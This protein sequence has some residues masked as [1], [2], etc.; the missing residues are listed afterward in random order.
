MLL[1]TCSG[2]NRSAHL[3]IA[4]GKPVS[5][6][7][8]REE[9]LV[10][11]V[12]TLVGVCLSTDRGNSQQRCLHSANMPDLEEK[13][14]KKLTESV[15]CRGR[16][17]LITKGRWELTRI[18]CMQRASLSHY[19]QGVE[20]ALAV[21]GSRSRRRSLGAY[22]TLIED[23]SHQRKYN[24]PPPPPALLRHGTI[25]RDLETCS[26]DKYLKLIP[27]QIELGQVIL[28]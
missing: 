11:A 6:P 4:T 20:A 21:R 9:V 8:R 12:C 15:A 22:N 13:E 26:A 3:F 23:L 19:R 17:C 5:V 10:R 27:A 1:M 28:V 25:L 18:V 2:R 14:E 7:H 16:A 24:P